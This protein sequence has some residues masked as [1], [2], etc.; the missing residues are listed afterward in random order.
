M[1]VRASLWFVPGLMFAGAIALALGLVAL[2]V[3]TDD[4]IIRRWPVL[5]ITGEGA[6]SILETVAGSVITVAGVV[7]SITIVAL[8]LAANQYSPRVLRSFMRDTGNRVVI[9]YFVAVFTYCLLVLR[10]IR[11][12]DVEFVPTLAALAG[13]LFGVLSAG[14]LIYFI[15]H[16]AVSLT[17]SYIVANLAGK[18]VER[19][20]ALLPEPEGSAGEEPREQED[21]SPAW[22]EIPAAAT[23]Y[24]QFIDIRR[25]V[26]AA[27]KRGTVVRLEQPVGGFVVAGAALARSSKG[28]PRELVRDVNDAVIVEHYRTLDQDPLYGIRQIVDIAVKALSPG[29]NDT[30]TAVMCV[31]YLTS[32]LVHLS[33]RASQPCRH[34]HKGALC[35]IVRGVSFEAAVNEA[36]HE[37]RQ[38]TRDNVEVALRQLDGLERLAARAMAPERRELLLRHARL[39]E[40]A[41]GRAI[42]SEH[43][44]EVVKQRLA[45]VVA[46]ME[47]RAQ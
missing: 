42:A 37:I 16:I 5:Q 21:E 28:A 11:A 26:R 1:Q 14:F 18:T 6:R 13:I 33:A 10:T 2:G 22:R 24:I 17:A 45:R 20:D 27:Q 36:F 8:T 40:Q 44:R 19:I 29:I 47:E 46:A 25:L 39:V 31:D 4:W 34:Y 38:N 43:D 30:T 3:R 35:A 15:N 12:G 23:G 9:G 41:A 7:F 32:V